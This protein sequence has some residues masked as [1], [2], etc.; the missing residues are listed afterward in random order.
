MA[1]NIEELKITPEKVIKNIKNEVPMDIDADVLQEDENGYE[2]VCN[3]QDTG[4]A[5]KKEESKDI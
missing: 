5:L 3:Q 4:K 2:S 1:D